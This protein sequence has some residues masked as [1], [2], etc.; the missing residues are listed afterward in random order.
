MYM[1]FL[2]GLY[3]GAL[4]SLAKVV[5]LLFTLTLIV[6]AFGIGLAYGFGQCFGQSSCSDTA[7]SAFLLFPAT[8]VVASIWLYRRWRKYQ[9]DKY[10]AAVKDEVTEEMYGQGFS[11]SEQEERTILALLGQ[12]KELTLEELADKSTIPKE[13][14]FTI[15]RKLLQ[16]ERITQKLNTSGNAY[17]GLP[18][19]GR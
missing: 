13:R 17:F 14:L 8:V 6:A 15:T 11:S 5:I 18:G 9:A 19:S 4:G 3:K 10:H 7:Q 16:A 1:D 12:Y 2:F